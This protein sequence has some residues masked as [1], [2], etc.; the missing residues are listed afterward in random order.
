MEMLG[1][2]DISAI[3]A[4]FEVLNV[5]MDKDPI[6]TTEDLLAHIFEIAEKGKW[7]QYLLS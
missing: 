3:K 7:S 1:S 5:H 6:Q 4:P 2:K